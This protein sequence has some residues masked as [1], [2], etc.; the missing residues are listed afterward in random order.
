MLVHSRHH[1]VPLILILS[2][3]RQWNKQR[4]SFFVIQD[5][6]KTLLSRQVAGSG[7]TVISAGG[8][9]MVLKSDTPANLGSNPT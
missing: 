2:T 8:T 1:K 6:E 3:F 5:V 4:K 9:S 7:T